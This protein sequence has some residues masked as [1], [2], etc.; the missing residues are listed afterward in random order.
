MDEGP[1][2]RRRDVK[3]LK[4]AGAEGTRVVLEHA[5]RAEPAKYAAMP[6][7]VEWPRFPRVTAIA[8]ATYPRRHGRWASERKR[9][10]ETLGLR[11]TVL[12]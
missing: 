12:R 3:H 9:K 6:D 8:T 4:A 5:R 2:R 1:F 11:R 10:T 7:V